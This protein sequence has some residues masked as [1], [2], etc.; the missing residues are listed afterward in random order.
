MTALPDDILSGF[1]LKRVS[2][3]V[4]CVTYGWDSDSESLVFQ[5]L[6][7]IFVC[8]GEVSCNVYFSH[9]VPCSS[10]EKESDIRHKELGK[11]QE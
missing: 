9:C 1:C 2:K 6:L 7:D 8:F 10:L 5:G 11:E 4:C 3:I